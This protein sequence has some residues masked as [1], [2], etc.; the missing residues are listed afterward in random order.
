MSETPFRSRAFRTARDVAKAVKRL[1][2]SGASEVYVEYDERDPNHSNTLLVI[3]KQGAIDRTFST[4][5]SLKPDEI[6]FV[7]G[8]RLWKLWFD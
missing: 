1:Y 2:E 4:I 3:G 6:H 7:R 5:Y 8:E